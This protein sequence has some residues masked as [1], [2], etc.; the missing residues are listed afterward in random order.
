LNLLLIV[1]KSY[2]FSFIQM[3]EYPVISVNDAARI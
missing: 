3:K 2:K 1:F